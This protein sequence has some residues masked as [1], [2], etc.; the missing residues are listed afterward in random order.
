MMENP[1][2][3]DEALNSVSH[4]DVTAMSVEEMAA[5][6]DPILR[7]HNWSV[8]KLVVEAIVQKNLKNLGP[9]PSVPN[10]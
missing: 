5:T 7:T 10:E 3:M 6:L 4:I 1:V 8:R 2:S 9:R